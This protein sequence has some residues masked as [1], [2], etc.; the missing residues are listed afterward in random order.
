[1]RSYLGVLIRDRAQ[2]CREPSN[3]F[4]ASV[5]PPSMMGTWSLSSPSGSAAAAP[6]E[7][8]NKGVGGWCCALAM[9]PV[10]RREL[11][12]VCC[13]LG[14]VNHSLSVQARRGWRGGRLGMCMIGG[15]AAPCSGRGV[16]E[17]SWVPFV[18]TLLSV[19]CGR[20]G[21]DVHVMV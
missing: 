17:L 2:R 4:P 13:L 5:S 8:C 18:R 15:R 19:A 14:R 6:L 1:M 3:S 12:I 9:E 7:S 11:E 16:P 10:V 21:R 20:K